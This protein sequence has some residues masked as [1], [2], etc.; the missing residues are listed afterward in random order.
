MFVFDVLFKNA[1]IDEGALF[2][3]GVKADWFSQLHNVA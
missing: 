3:L 1:S 2:V